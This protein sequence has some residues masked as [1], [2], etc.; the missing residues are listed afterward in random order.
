MSRRAVPSRSSNRQL[1][2]V[3][4]RGHLSRSTLIALACVA[5]IG[6]G[7]SQLHR[8][9]DLQKDT[10]EFLVSWTANHGFTVQDVQLVGR[11]QVSAD[12]VMGALQIE[13][14]MPIFHYD[15]KAAQERLIENPWIQSAK[16]ERRL[17]HTIFIRVVER[18]PAARWQVDGKLVLVDTSGTVLATEAMDHYRHLP[19]IVGQ[20]ARHKLVS[21][22]ELLAAEPDIGR[23]VVAATWIGNRRWDLTL[24]NNIVV[25]LPASQPEIAMTQLAALDKSQQV[26]ERDLL[27]IDLR[28]PEKAVL[29][30]TIRANALIERPDFSDTPDLSKKNI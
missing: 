13:R 15:P 3:R 20:D 21:L 28:L 11:K 19:I 5:C 27:S 25:R 1:T 4:Q 30:P 18:E 10:K 7:I 12:F 2:R 16:I 24:K 9:P 26:L 14:D 22:F 23:H 8:V 6:L 17:P 29:Q